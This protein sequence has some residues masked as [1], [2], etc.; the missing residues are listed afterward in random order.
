MKTNRITDVTKII[1]FA[2]TIVIVCVMVALGFKIVNEG[3]SSITNGT[4]QYND[5][6]AEYSD[7]NIT[8]YDGSYVLGSEVSNLI[9]KTV[10]KNPDLAIRV[11]TKA[12][13]TTSDYNRTI[14][15]TLP[16]VTISVA[17]TRGL[18]TLTT[19]STANA[20]INPTGSFLGT[21]YK[22]ANGVVNVI[23]FTQQ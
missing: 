19:L 23:V 18:T 4:S 6:A 9:T 21:T 16:N 1:I 15:G 2:A 11:I 12:G 8:N 22:N 5:M 7:I 14:T 13:P 3:K 10:S 17:A 20:Y